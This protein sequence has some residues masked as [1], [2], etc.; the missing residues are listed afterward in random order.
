MLSGDLERVT[1]NES[2][3][4]LKERHLC[5]LV[6]RKEVPTS[7]GKFVSLMTNISPQM[8]VLTI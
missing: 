4:D 3:G 1:G 7:N 6:S 5:T 2:I 8:L